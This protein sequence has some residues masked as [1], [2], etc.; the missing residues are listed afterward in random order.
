M[1]VLIGFEWIIVN[2]IV[3]VSINIF[4]K[5][6]LDSVIK[7]QIILLTEVSSDEILNECHQLWML[8]QNSKTWPIQ[9]CPLHFSSFFI[10]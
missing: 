1:P 2:K 8:L 7:N 10:M 3:Q 9:A 5:N 6:R 4:A